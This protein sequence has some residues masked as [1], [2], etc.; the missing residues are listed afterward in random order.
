MTAGALP[1][2]SCSSKRLRLLLHLLLILVL[3][4]ACR[5]RQRRDSGL[6][7]G[8][9]SL[10]PAITE[11]LFAIGAGPHVA[12]VSDYCHFPAEVERL[13]HLGS[14][15]TPRYE[16]IVGL[17]PTAVFVEGV[18]AETT[19]ALAKILDVKVLP[20][21]TLE[22][23]VHS[24]RELG[25]Y[26]RQEANAERLARSYEHVMQPRVS[27]ASPRVLLVL[28]HPAGQLRE[29]W[30]IRRNSI[31]GR[32]LEAAGALNAVAD[33]ISGPPHLSLE[34]VIRLDPDGIVVLQAAEHG[35][36]RLL[37]DWRRLQALTAV[38]HGRLQLVA[39]PEVT[40]PGPRI[41]ELVQRL[42]PWVRAW[43]KTP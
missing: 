16:A 9:V 33:E 23:V 42:S 1:D 18:N 41:I 37:D 15:Y 2:Q 8:F 25:R 19:R 32:V 3:L 39:A 34:Q 30:V 10:S 26:T 27:A 22:Q 13:P 14:G 29:A 36:P 40:I 38:Q 31:H 7:G 17:Q 24:T 21:L 11:T 4:T 12:G 35:N 20:W 6:H 5:S 28:A 43:S